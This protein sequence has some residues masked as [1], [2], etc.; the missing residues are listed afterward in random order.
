MTKGS[1]KLNGKSGGLI[2]HH[3]SHYTKEI[4]QRWYHSKV[5]VDADSKWLIDKENVSS[6]YKI[7]YLKNVHIYI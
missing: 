1:S 6:D 5:I 3:G 7:L 4:G 2:M